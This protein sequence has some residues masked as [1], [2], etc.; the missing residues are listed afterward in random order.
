MHI[1]IVNKIQQDA[2]VLN[3]FKKLF[4]S[5]LFCST[6]FG[7]S[8]AHHQEPLFFLHIFLYKTNLMHNFSS[9]L[10]ITL[11]VS[12][13]LSV[14]SSGV[15]DCTY[16]IRYMPYRLVNCMLTCPLTCSQHT[17]HTHQK[18]PAFTQ[19]YRHKT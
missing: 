17:Q 3:S 15:L 2:P 13:G 14:P 5:L 6:C 7:H 16:S 4:Y 11:H 9:L 10:N 12:D 19:Q 18:T 8:C 1:T